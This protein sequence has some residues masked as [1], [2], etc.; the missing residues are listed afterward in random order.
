MQDLVQTSKQRD[1]QKWGTKFFKTGNYRIDSITFC[2]PHNQITLMVETGTNF[3][4]KLKSTKII[5]SIQYLLL[6]E[7][8]IKLSKS[9]FTF[10]KSGSTTIMNRTKHLNPNPSGAWAFQGFVLRWR[11]VK[12]TPSHPYLKLVRIMLE[13]RNLVRKY[14]HIC[15]FKIYTCQCQSPLNF[16]NVSIVFCEKSVFSAKM[17]LL[18]KAIV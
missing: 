3:H 14:T 18:L 15:S 2:H 8:S 7:K 12:I 4:K 1:Y 17:V 5:K 6:S 11:V 10:F 13:T 9:Q 16:A